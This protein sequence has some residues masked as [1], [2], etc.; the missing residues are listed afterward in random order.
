MG[1]LITGILK[2]VIIPPPPALE[3]GLKFKTE[4]GK[5][6]RNSKLW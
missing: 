1:N 5:R 2:N 6:E 3:S 4:E